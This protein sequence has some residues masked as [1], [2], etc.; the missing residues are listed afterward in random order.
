MTGTRLPLLS[1]LGWR[2]LWRH[3]RRTLVILVAITLGV[4]FMVVSAAMMTG[5]IEQ[6]INDTIFNLTGHAQIHHPRFRD[7]PAIEHSMPVPG[8]GLLEIL[9]SSDVRQ[10]S[11]RVRLPAIVMSERESRGVTLVGIDPV[12]EQGLAFIGDPVIEGRPLQSIDD[13]GIVIGQRMAEKLET[14]IGKRIVVM[15]QD[16]ANQVADRG[17]RIV[18]LFRAELEATETAY[19]FTGRSTVQTLL[20]MADEVSEIS[21]MTRSRENL[22]SLVAGIRRA[23]PQFETLS[24]QELEPLIVTAMAVYENFIF[25]WYL[26][27]FTAM[28]FGLTNTMLMA[29][30]ERT[31]EIG[32]LQA[33]GMRPRLIV[34]QVMLESLILLLLG[35]LLGNLLGWL[36]T[37]IILRGGIDLSAF[38]RGM[39][40]F[41]MGSTMYFIWRIEDLITIDALVIALGLLSSLYPAVKAARYVPVEAITRI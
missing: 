34:G 31:R 6:Q 20:G 7:D 28:A 39:E 29:V 33:L 21:L 9:N 35:V 10:W 3:P 36:T 30:F 18:G 23:A 2:N 12:R 22:E 17:F 26:I 24:W 37:D 8:E 1:T 11:S 27:I 16:K 38:A 40:Q 15:S 41:T 4:W 19:V 32:L 25:I 14:R 13:N 5:L